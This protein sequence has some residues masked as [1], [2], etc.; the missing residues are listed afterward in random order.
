[1]HNFQNLKLHAIGEDEPPAY[2]RAQDELLLMAARGEWA[3]ETRQFIRWV[4]LKDEIPHDTFGHIPRSAIELQHL[5]ASQ[6]RV[7]K[8]MI[9]ECPIVI[10]Q[11]KLSFKLA[12]SYSA[13]PRA[14]RDGEDVRHRRNC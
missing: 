13:S 1:M 4:F 8:A 10:T 12:V 3:P 5:N 9:S 2:Q 14:T 7:V 6:R 11:G